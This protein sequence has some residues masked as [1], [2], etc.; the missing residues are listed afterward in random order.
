MKWIICMAF[1]TGVLCAAPN[2]GRMER[3]RLVEVNIRGVAQVLEA[4]DNE[5]TYEV[6]DRINVDQAVFCYRAFRASTGLIKSDLIHLLKQSGFF[7]EGDGAQ[8]RIV[9]SGLNKSGLCE[10]YNDEIEARLDKLERRGIAYRYYSRRIM[11]DA[12]PSMKRQKR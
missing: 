7:I 5:N 12:G 9:G 1:M 4:I 10:Q 3:I 2:T 11:L 6:D 8:K